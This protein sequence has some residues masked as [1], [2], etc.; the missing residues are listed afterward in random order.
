MSLLGIGDLLT[1]ES[2][3]RAIASFR[4]SMPD[5]V[6]WA[7]TLVRRGDFEVWRTLDLDEVIATIWRQL[8]ERDH[9]GIQNP[10]PT[11]C[12]TSGASRQ[13]R[14]GQNDHRKWIPFRHGLAGS[15]P[16]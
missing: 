9:E 4:D 10:C 1:R 14:F 15:G 2:G 5:L 8:V 13:V 6:E 16:H 3:E 12:P 7:L 11:S